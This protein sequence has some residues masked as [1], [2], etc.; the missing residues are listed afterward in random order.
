VAVFC[1]QRVVC[2][3]FESSGGR[4]KEYMYVVQKVTAG[5][6]TRLD[7]LTSYDTAYSHS[8]LGV[9]SDSEAH[10][11]LAF[12][13]PLSSFILLVQRSLVVRVARYFVSFK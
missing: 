2:A 10:H 1:W 8:H 4:K 12:G 6:V 5:W 7:S 13:S 11:S 9:S 3:K